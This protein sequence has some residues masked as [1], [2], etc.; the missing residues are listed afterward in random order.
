VAA[1]CEEK[2]VLKLLEHF[3]TPDF[4]KAQWDTF[5]AA[6]WI[7]VPPLL[8]SGVVGWLWKGSSDKGEIRELKAARNAAKAESDAYKARMDLV[9]DKSARDTKEI[10]ALRMDIQEIKQAPVLTIDLKLTIEDAEKR[11]ITLASSNNEIRQ[12]VSEPISIKETPISI[13][14]RSTS[15]TID[16]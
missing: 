6:P 9:E 11:A 14:S 12:I 5:W 7:Y 10:A 15:D 1:A 4:W 8:I 3:L 13:T 16:E 2:G